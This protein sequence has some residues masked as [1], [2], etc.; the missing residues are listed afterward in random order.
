[1]YIPALSGGI[2]LLVNVD[3]AGE[4]ILNTTMAGFM[5]AFRLKVSDNFY[6]NTAL[7][8]TFVQKSLDWEKLIFPDQID[9]R[10]GIIHNTN[11]IPPENL[12]KNFADFS[13][14]IAGYGDRYY[15]GFSASHVTT[16]NEGFTSTSY[17]PVRF[18]LHA[19]GKMCI[20]DRVWE[21]ILIK[22]LFLQKME[23]N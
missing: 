18:T 2:G 16:P 14:G 1:M 4:G 15:F 19:G 13:A 5:Y 20:R 7:Q 8:A 10:W 9:P 11:E 6:I 23:K 22:L 17:L 12:T 21:V 3:R